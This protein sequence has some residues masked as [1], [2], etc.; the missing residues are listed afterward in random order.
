MLQTEEKSAFLDSTTTEEDE[1][2]QERGWGRECERVMRMDTQ[3]VD[4]LCEDG[5]DDGTGWEDGGMR[6]MMQT[7]SM[8]TGIWNE[9]HVYLVAW[10]RVAP[11]MVQM[12]LYWKVKD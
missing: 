8:M 11:S 12:F 1:R 2:C 5:W 9:Y 6:E 7:E 3:L 4:A 10:E